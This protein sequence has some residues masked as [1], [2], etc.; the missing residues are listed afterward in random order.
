[1]EIVKAVVLMMSI[2]MTLNMAISAANFVASNPQ[3]EKQISILKVQIIV[4]SFLW[5][6]Y[7]YIFNLL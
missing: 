4:T 3:N 1:M 5:A 7:V 6:V 2:Y